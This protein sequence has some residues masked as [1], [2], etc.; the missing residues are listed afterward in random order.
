MAMRGSVYSIGSEKLR[1]KPINSKLR[2]FWDSAAH[3]YVA[4]IG[5]LSGVR[6]SGKTMEKALLGLSMDMREQVE[7][8]I[9]SG[10]NI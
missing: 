3:E 9:M 5:L 1:R 10:N 4:T 6:G 2:I 8:I 7:G